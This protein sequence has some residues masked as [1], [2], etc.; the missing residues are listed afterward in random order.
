MRVL[1]VEDEPAM[2]NLAAKMLARLGCKVITAADGLEAVQIMR[3]H[4]GEIELVLLDLTMPGMNGWET[5]AAL[6]ELRAD[7]AVVL[8]SGY[9]EAHVMERRRAELPQALLHKPYGMRELQEAIGRA[10]I[11]TTVRR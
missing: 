10:M 1:V 11:P 3:E 5:L 9:D 6:R 8:A 7:I 4:E 2:R